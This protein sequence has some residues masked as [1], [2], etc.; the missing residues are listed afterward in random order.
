[1]TS[2][3]DL[4]FALV[5][6]VPVFVGLEDAQLV[7]IS[8]PDGDVAMFD[9]G[10]VTGFVS[11][12]PAAVFYGAAMERQEEMQQAAAA[13]Q[14]RRA[15][16]FQPR[17]QLFTPLPRG[18]VSGFPSSVLLGHRTETPSLDTV[19]LSSLFAVS[20]VRTSIEQAEK[21]FSCFVELYEAAGRTLPDVAEIKRCFRG[22]QN[23]KSKMFS[24]VAA[25]AP[26]IQQAI[27]S[28]LRDR[29]LRR[30][31]VRETDLPTGLGVTKVSFTLALLGHDCVCLDGRLLNRMFQPRDRALEI[32]AG[33]GKTGKHVSELALSRYEAVEDAFL[34]G[35]RH[36][37]ARDPLGRARAQWRSWESVGGKGATHSV[38]LKV[39]TKDASR[40][41][42]V[43]SAPTGQE[44][45]L[46]AYLAPMGMVEQ[47]GPETEVS[48]LPVT[49]RHGLKGVIRRY[50]S[51]HG[52]VRY[53]MLEDGQ[54]VG[55]LQVVTTD[56]KNAIIA[57]VYVL[58]ERRRAGVAEALLVR[59]REDFQHVRHAQDLSPDAAAWRNEVGEAVRPIGPPPPTTASSSR[60][61]IAA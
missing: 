24:E 27:R 41:L 17:G 59:A 43:A 45:D 9:A 60:P 34:E 26:V 49:T 55:A 35:N 29:E 28:G 11:I 48:W 50:D 56:F 61:S 22:L 3:C 5:D 2:G 32:E 57:N 36:Y 46:S 18:E 25:Y 6:G 12:D 10:E 33:W 14:R 37:N 21:S 31:L 30:H 58:P 52:S 15:G 1:M 47:I 20:T 16:R 7:G 54:L 39:V 40:G 4:P 13:P 53:V 44:M 38:W 51:Q 23:T 42:H 8:V 19:R